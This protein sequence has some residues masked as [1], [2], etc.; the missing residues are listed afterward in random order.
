MWCLWATVG[1]FLNV[2][3]MVY[4]R[5]TQKSFVYRKTGHFHGH[6]TIW[7]SI[8]RPLTYMYNIYGFRL[9]SGIQICNLI[10]NV[11]YICKD[12]TV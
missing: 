7:H 9:M 1:I 5:V 11:L 2:I 6:V 4:L 8:Y 10:Y 3:S 12:I